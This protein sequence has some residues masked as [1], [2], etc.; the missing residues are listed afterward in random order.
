LLC[1]IVLFILGLLWFCNGNPLRVDKGMYDTR[2]SKK[3]FLKRYDW[4]SDEEGISRVIWGEV[5]VCAFVSAGAK[6]PY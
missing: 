1:A 2:K 5:E 3:F 4:V 6:A